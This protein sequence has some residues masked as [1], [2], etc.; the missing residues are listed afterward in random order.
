MPR[1]P[2]RSRSSQPTRKEI[3]R[4]LDELGEEDY[5]DLEEMTLAEQI[6]YETEVVDEDAGVVQIK[7]TG[8]L[9]KQVNVDEEI[10]AGLKAVHGDD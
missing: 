8:E 5:G 6:A 7:E 2:T 4:R 3:N 1:R 10:M 9:R